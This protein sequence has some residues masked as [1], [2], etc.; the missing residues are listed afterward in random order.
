MKKEITRTMGRPVRRVD[1]KHRGH[2]VEF[3]KASLANRLA[4][5]LP[6]VFL[7]RARVF[8]LP[9]RFEVFLG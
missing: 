8:A 7:F 2:L 6:L 3:H 9:L 4:Y 1:I 5:R